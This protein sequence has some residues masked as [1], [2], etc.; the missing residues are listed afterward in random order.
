MLSTTLIDVFI[1]L[2]LGLLVG[3]Q[4]ERAASPLAGLRTFALVAVMGAVAA[5][6]SEG[7]GPWV[8]V[9]GLLAVTALM[10]IG[11]VVLLHS[12]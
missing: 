8:I 3:L 10:V 9:A 11:N 12:G 4:K 2:G 5:V 7:S 1:A 6:L